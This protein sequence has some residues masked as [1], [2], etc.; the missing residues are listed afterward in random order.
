MATF[1]YIARGG[2]T[3]EQEKGFLWIGRGGIRLE[4]TAAAGG[5][6]PKGPLGHPLHGA[7]AGPIG[8]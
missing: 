6:T 2:Q 7:L 8:P 5:A 4:R 1:N 3:F